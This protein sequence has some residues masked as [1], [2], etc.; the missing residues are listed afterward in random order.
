MQIHTSTCNDI[1]SLACTHTNTDTR[2]HTHSHTHNIHITRMRPST[3]ALQYGQRPPDIADGS[4]LRRVGCSDR[5]K[6]VDQQELGAVTSRELA[7]QAHGPTSKLALPANA[8][9]RQSPI[10]QP[11]MTLARSQPCTHCAHAHLAES[12]PPREK[13]RKLPLQYPER[14]AY[15]L[16]QQ[17]LAVSE[18]HRA[19]LTLEKSDL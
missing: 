10:K 5:R 14:F 7:G 8:D 19:G 1:H 13:A 15:S 4:H 18:Q 6:G 12:A 2:P 11:R 16:V 3:C 9:D 17:P